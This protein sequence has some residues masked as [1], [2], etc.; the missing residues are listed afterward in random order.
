MKLRLFNSHAAV[1][2]VLAAALLPLRGGAQKPDATIPKVSIDQPA[3]TR[4]GGHKA[5]D[6]IGIE[7][8]NP[9]GE[10]LGRVDD[11]VVDL[12]SGKASYVILTIGG[13]LGIGDTRVAVPTRQFSYTSTETEKNLVLDTTRD[14]LQ[15]A[16][17]YTKNQAIDAKWTTE[18]DVFYGAKGDSVPAPS[19]AAEGD[20]PSALDS[21]K[22]ST[23][24]RGETE[25]DLANKVRVAIA[26]ETTTVPPVRTINVTAEAGVVRLTGEVRSRE[27]KQQI[28]ARARQVP[29]VM[30]IENKLHVKK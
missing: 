2:A 26:A 13:V 12:S 8:K 3:E 20:S 30:R 28:E 14:K 6:L 24:D 10:R 21:G 9:K 22:Q 7:V 1:I 11:L 4:G 5:S 17:R 23:P 15:D 27:E 16:P 25:K 18:V 19:K 29:G